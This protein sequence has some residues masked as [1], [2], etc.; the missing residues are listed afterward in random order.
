MRS[1]FRRVPVQQ[2]LQRS[3]QMLTFPAPIGGWYTAGN[4]D[5]M[6]PATAYRLE[7]WRC[8][9]TG[10][11]QRGGSLKYATITD[12]T[13]P[14]V[15][16]IT[17]NAS[18]KKLF[19]ATQTKI[20]DLT[21]VA[22]PSVIP[23]SAAVTGQTHGY[24][25]YVNFTN[26]G[27]EYLTVANGVDPLQLYDPIG[28]WRQ[29]TTSSS[30]IS[31]TNIGN[32]NELSFVW[33]YRNRQFFTGRGMLAYCLPVGSVGGALVKIDLNGVFQR[34]GRL[35][36]GA[37]WSLDAGDGLDDKCVF[38]TTEGEVAVY[39]G[40]DPS[41][42]AT[43]SLVGRY[44]LARP[45]GSRASLRSGGDVLISTEIGLLPLSKAVNL[46]VTAMEQAAVSRAISPDWKREAKAR[47]A[48]PWEVVKY[49]DMSYAIFSLPGSVSDQ[50]GLCY[51]VNT[52][53]GAWSYYTGW[54]ARCLA[55]HDGV[56]YFGTRTGKV[57]QAE[58]GGKDDGQPIYYTCIANPDHFQTPS[59]LKT[60]LQ[61][62]AKFKAATPFVAQ[63][64]ASVDNEIDLPA[65]PDPSPDIGGGSSLW[66]I[67]L[68]DVALW[69]AAQAM[70]SISTTRAGIKC[71]GYVVQWQLQ[72]TGSQTTYPVI[73]LISVNLSFET[74]KPLL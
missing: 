74:G 52:E 44:D 4:L 47:R 19:A 73:E 22:D 57:F 29:I 41:N 21:T 20:F 50:L 18:V 37:S 68:W 8:T 13:A 30:P 5:A 15:S 40:A 48:L 17:Y 60:V 66:G 62:Q 54:D 58:F 64:T 61:A 67:G 38:V 43:W 56:L 27:G 1:N 33:L 63:I 7:N 59:M 6:P 11:A 9:T 42:V 49:A 70:S 2:P 53:T 10:I 51:V 72:I 69:D 45:L 36:F 25:S 12:G 23:V 39:E 32:T 55:L 34:G 65:A 28:G 31:I 46:D 71:T 14:V 24:Y 26:S 3:R 16:F 35:L